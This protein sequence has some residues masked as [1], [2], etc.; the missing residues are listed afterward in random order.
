[1]GLCEANQQ[2]SKAIKAVKSGRDV[3]LTERGKPIAVIK[4]LNASARDEVIIH[5]LEAEG[6]LR[7]AAKRRPLPS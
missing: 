2:F 4:P 1:M 3:V 7:A 5:R 6:L